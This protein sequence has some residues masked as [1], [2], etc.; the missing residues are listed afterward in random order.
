M[1]IPFHKVHITDQEIEAVSQ[2]LKSGWL[3][4]GPKT[5]AFEAAFREVIGSPVAIATSSATAALHLALKAIGLSEND[6]VI[7]P[8]ITFV[9]TA[10]VVTY[11]KAI[12]VLC[13]VLPDTHTLDPNQ[14]QTLITPKTKAIIPVH[15]AGIPCD[16]DAILEIAK[17]HH[18]PVIEDAAHA[19]PATYKGRAIGTIGDI[20][21]FS[22]YAS[23][24][25]T[26]GEGGMITT[27]N[28]EWAAAIKTNRIHGLSRDVWSRY[29]TPT[30]WDY[31]AIDNGFKYNMT[32]INAAIGLVQLQKAET[33]KEKRKQL[34]KTYDHAFQKAGIDTLQIPEYAD[35]A[36]H[37]YIIKIPNRD[38]VYKTLLEK[39][40][41]TAVHYRP[42]HL[43]PYYQ[44]QYHFDPTRFPV[45]NRLFDTSLSLPLYPDL[46][47]TDQAYIIQSVLD[48]F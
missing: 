2:T 8:S 15:F 36:Y 42:I 7:L 47:P 17:T 1:T 4:M 6:E 16:M 10:E 20:T 34:A 44:S 33:L 32:D 31:E 24:T 28:S 3:S 22:F 13:D 39:G 12:P 9:A 48:V 5:L 27:A 37:F 46:D 19:F 41:T 11:F 25:I 18:I 40:I 26:C 35:S 43:Q 14:L 30:H 38:Q 45:S 29:E 23:K 21:C